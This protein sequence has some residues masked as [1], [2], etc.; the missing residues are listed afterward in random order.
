MQIRHL[1]ATLAMLVG[2][3][4]GAQ[5]P[6]TAAMTRATRLL[7]AACRRDADGTW[8][9][10]LCGPLLL[11]HWGQ[12][13]LT[14]SRRPADGGFAAAGPWW[15][16]ALGDG[17]FPANTAITLGGTRWSMVVLPL[18]DDDA[19]AMQLLV[20][21][22]FHRIQGEL[23]LPA[24]DPRNDQL[25]AP[26]ARRWLRLE[27]RALAR[28]VAGEGEA[29]CRAARDALAF[30]A[31]R[32]AAFAGS[33]ASEAALERHE[34]LAEYT[35]HR[36][37]SL[38][39]PGGDARLVNALHEAESKPSYVRSFAYATGPAYGTLLD[40]VD[41]TWREALGD[42]ASPADHLARAL[43]CDPG[44]ATADARAA[45]YG[46]DELARVERQRADSLGR[47][48]DD[49]LARL[50]AGPVLETPDGQLNFTFDPNRVFPLGDHGVVHPA[51][52]YSG[53]WGSL[54]VTAG[55]ALV[56]ADYRRVRVALPTDGV[57]EWKLTPAA[58]WEVEKRPDGWRLVKRDS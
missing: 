50:V 36:L 18:P 30:R 46:G 28:A 17:Q 11:A 27:W 1:L 35:G 2:E 44:T 40:R 51:G 33:A 21:E 12:R 52:N 9:V 47:I 49:Y 53:P 54:E 41:A 3:P 15:T 26:E 58:G 32:H 31:A 8:G 14:A 48:R 42:G 22:Q 39:F 10:S 4:L 37:A 20:H 7:D 34:G 24:N 25:D 43:T 55:G 57:S 19:A 16:G 38:A 23:G 5:R 6:D 56:S 29:A 45:S 13:D